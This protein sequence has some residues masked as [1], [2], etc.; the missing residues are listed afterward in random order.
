MWPL[1]PGSALA[2]AVAVDRDPDGQTTIAAYNRGG[3]PVSARNHEQTVSLFGDLELQEPGVVQVHKW[4]PT[5]DDAQLSD[6]DVYMYGG[7]AF[8]R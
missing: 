4:R 7:V 6:E 3:V 2:V 1:A 8:K 5:G